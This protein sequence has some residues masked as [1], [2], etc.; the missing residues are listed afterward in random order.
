MN[1]FLW[2]LV[3]FLVLVT[4]LGVGLTLKP[5]EVPSPLIDKPAPI[6]TLPQLASPDQS[7]SPV[8]MKGEVWLLNVWASWCY[9]CLEE[10]GLIMDLAKTYSLP[11]VGLNYKDVRDE[12]LAWLERNGNAYTVSVSDTQ[13][14]VGIDYGVYG[15]PETFVIDKDGVIRYKHIG[16]VTP[17][18]VRDT[19]LPLVRRLQQ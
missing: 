17:N 5:S 9:A 4:F 6:F 8:M 1:R 13:G 7:F 19:L 18:V 11:I 12:A 15:V 10:H 16:A 2:P 14:R 3:G